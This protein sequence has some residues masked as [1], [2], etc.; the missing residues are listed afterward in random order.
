VRDFRGSDKGKVP[1]VEAQNNPFAFVVTEFYFFDF[2]LVKGFGL[3]IRCLLGDKHSF[4]P[5]RKYLSAD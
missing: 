4:T 1:G 5:F 2:A 3:K